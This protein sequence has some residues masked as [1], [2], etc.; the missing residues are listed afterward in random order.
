MSR[1]GRLR[2]LARA[3]I[4]AAILAVL[5]LTITT[6]GFVEYS[7]RPSFCNN[8]HIMEPYYESW[9]SSSHRDVACIECHYAPGIRAEAMGK[10]QA[11][12]Q[13][14]KY[15]TGAYDVKPWAEIEDAA[16]LR[17]GCHSERKVE[18]VVDYQ[19]VRFDH[20]E[21]LSELRRGKQLR[22]TSCHSQ[23][24]QGEHVAVTQSTCI[25]CHFKGQP[26]AAPIGGC[27]GCHAAPPRVVSPAGYVVD[28][29]QYVRDR[30]SCVS[31]HSEVT[32][33]T[34]DAEESRCFG[35]HNEPDRL[36]QFENTTLL[37][38]VHIAERNVEC[39]Q[40]HTPIQHRVVALA[41]TFELDCASC[42][43]RVHDAQRRLYAGMGGHATKDAPSKMFLARVSCVGCH[44]LPAEV[45]GHEGVRLAGEASCLS[46]H[47]IRYANMLPSWQREMDRKLGRV[48]PVV[49]GA[50]ASLGGAR[51]G[52][53][54][55]ADS[56]LR[57]AQNNVDFVR[58]GKAAHNVLYADQLLRA[59]LTLVEEAVRAG[60]LPYRVPAIDLG[61]PVGA[62][63]CFACHLGA[64]RAR[65]PF[66][67]AMFGH[68]PHVLR[69]GLGCA[70]CHT[71]LER[72]GGT[73]LTS[74][75]AC[76]ACHHA[77]IRPMNCARCHTGPGGAPDSIMRLAAGDFA[78]APH[79]EANLA[80]TACH[81]PPAMSARDLRCAQCHAPHHQPEASCLSC[82]RG[83]ALR[84]H[85]RAAHVACV[86]CHQT[87]PGLTQWSR[88]VC[89]VCHT[90]RA[91]G[92]YTGKACETCHK[93]PPFSAPRG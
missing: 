6:V 5:L 58:V 74:P 75:A 91:T 18:G 45:R 15:V 37:H 56:L 29:D 80:C 16:C 47:G 61:A 55:A 63:A 28:H 3:L 9:A 81:T 33:G 67:G 78:H 92:H 89:A 53:R 14:V 93:V 23:I 59:S 88:Q 52:R 11:A 73:T 27:T 7:S 54:A 26:P 43:V 51:P 39:N 76:A 85:T 70:D 22:C 69:A 1:F 50:R 66:A 90:D 44:A 20:A 71:P 57:L 12:N 32:T 13:V 10:L 35:C 48:A 60:G 30:V 34:G 2:R 38:R 65:V 21:H 25:L 83:G 46:C 86:Q 36:G 24:V 64:E 77:Q 49:S 19:G 72:H 62:A 8:C 4:P 31:C 42:H 84:Y 68:A 40:C 41:T 82:H 87:T 79:R 17:S